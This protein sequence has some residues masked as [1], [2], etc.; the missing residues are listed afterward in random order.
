MLKRSKRIVSI[1]T[2]F[3]ILGFVSS[4]QANEKIHFIFNKVINDSCATSMSISGCEVQ[5]CDD[6][7]FLS[8]DSRHC[9]QTF[10][11]LKAKTYVSYMGEKRQMSAADNDRLIKSHVLSGSSGQNPAPNPNGQDFRVPNDSCA[12]GFRVGSCYYMKCDQGHYKRCDNEASFQG[13]SDD[14]WN[15][16]AQTLFASQHGKSGQTKH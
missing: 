11:L 8:P 1:F 16:N 9:V 2:L 13:I 12:V 10:D 7:Y 14:E 3:S 4:S 5:R 6:G 15:K